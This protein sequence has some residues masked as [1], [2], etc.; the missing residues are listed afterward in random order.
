MGYI[1]LKGSWALDLDE[2]S[3][4]TFTAKETTD[5]MVTKIMDIYG[6]DISDIEPGNGAQIR[7]ESPPSRLFL[8]F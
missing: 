3:L 8:R 1:G 6:V 7:R 2:S 5:F 4:G